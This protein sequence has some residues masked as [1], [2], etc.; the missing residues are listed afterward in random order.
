MTLFIYHLRLA[1]LS[2]RRSWGI[3]LVMLLALAMGN[4][5]WCLA[6]GQW[7]RFQGVEVHLS[8]AL[9]QVELLRP[10]DANAFFHDAAPANPYL[11]APSLMAR[12]QQSWPQARA[13][14]ESRVPARQSIGVRAEV[15]VRR[16]DAAT[17]V[18]R[19]A[20]FTNTAF[21]GMFER[22]FTAGGPWTEA[23]EAKGAP[24]VVLGRAT[25]RALF[26]AGGA[27]GATVFVEGRPHRVVGTLAE[28][29]PLNAPWALLI[30]GG[31]EDALFLPARELDRLGIVPD[32]PMPQSAFATGRDAVFASDARF[33]TSWVELPTPQ[34]VAAYEADLDRL[35]GPGN[36]V[37]RALPEWRR[38]LAMP[39]SQIS[40]FS[41]LGLIVLLGGAFNL[42]RWLL[43]RGLTR[44]EELGVYRAL[45][46]PRASI[47]ART[48]LEGLLLALPAALLAPLT[49]LPI[50]WMFNRWIHVVDMPLELSGLTVLVSAMSPLLMCALASLLPAWRLARTRPTLYLGSAR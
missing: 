25:A 26:P 12:T 29:Q 33:V 15:L 37:L 20:R 17:P 7:I 40:F 32:Q 3:S 28:Y 43:T 2:L 8:P 24:V 44:A 11:G 10:R 49:S 5:I 23:E 46:A 21:F 34:H 13:L 48:F 31:N 6:V 4:G 35:V 14:A 42:A 39:S 50:L 45:G 19:M 18:S 38:D 36:W 22:P 47:F 16:A 27:V 9:H 1:V 30:I 41:F